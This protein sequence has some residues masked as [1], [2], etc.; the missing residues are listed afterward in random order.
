MKTVAIIGLPN[1]GKSSLF[2]RI[3]KERIAITSDFSGTTRDVK[4]KEVLI[5]DRPCI[6][7]DTGGLDSSNEMFENVKIKSLEAAQNADIIIMMVDGKLLPSDEEKK[8]FYSLQKFNKPIALV[9]N[10]IDNDKEMQNAWEFDEFGAQ[11]VFPISV[12]HNRGVTALFKWIAEFLPAPLVEPE[13]DI[14]EDEEDIDLE[15]LLQK[16]E[17]IPEEDENES[18]QINVAIIGRT[19]VGKSSLLNA[20]VEKERAV[21][22]SIA[23]T[24]ID[25][26]DEFIEYEDKVINFVD[27]AGLRRRGKIEGIEKFALMRTNKMLESADIALLVL[28]ASEPFKELDERIANLAD[29]NNLAVIIVLNKWDKAYDEYE[30]VID[31]IKFRFKF[32]AYAPIITVSALSKKRVHKLKDLILQVYQNYSQRIPTSKLNE[33]FKE[34][35]SKHHMPS[36]KTKEVKIYFATQYDIKPPRIVL[37]MNRPKALH[38]SYKRYLM[39]QLREKFELEGTPVLLYARKRGERDEGEAL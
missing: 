31:E 12:S 20:L 14:E 15:T 10:K 11:K 6:I 36:D 34:A 35:V 37:V 29:T 33:L 13:L 30:K 17:E 25:P 7:I 26:V 22:S 27:T 8:I 18:N 24:T 3:A 19:N 5:L 2:N 38:F 23:G 9:I 1:V 28:D 4:D 21:V 39:N 32:L 16:E